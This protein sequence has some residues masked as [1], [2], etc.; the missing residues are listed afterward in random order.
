MPLT[1]IAGF[2]CWPL[3]TQPLAAMVSLRLICPAMPPST[4][5]GT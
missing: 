2:M 5:D 4:A 3:E 1:A